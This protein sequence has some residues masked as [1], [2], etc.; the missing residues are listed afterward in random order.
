MINLSCCHSQIEAAYYG[1]RDTIL[2]RVA[3]LFDA[4]GFPAEVRGQVYNIYTKLDSS[5]D[6]VISFDEFCN[7]FDLEETKFAHR[8]FLVLDQGVSGTLDF[9]SFILCAWNYCTYDKRGLAAFAFRLYDE[10]GNGAIPQEKMMDL[11]GEIYDI[12][13]DQASIADYGIDLRKNSPEYTMKKAK[14]IIRQAVGDDGVMDINE[15]IS[16]SSKNPMILKNAYIIQ[17]RL[18]IESKLCN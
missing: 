6:G 9:P 7:Y 17:I 2:E 3:P 13:G 11:I 10:D 15:F 4:L 1:R 14:N 12:G 5:H 16:F 8:S 18:Q